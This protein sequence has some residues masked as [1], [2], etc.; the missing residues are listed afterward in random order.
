[1]LPSGYLLHSHGKS[2]F[3]IGKP[4]I[5]MIHLYRGYVSHNLRVIHPSFPQQLPPLLAWSLQ[6]GF[7]A[8]TSDAAVRPLLAV[9]DHERNPFD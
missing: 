4:S 9:E 1:M 7:A 2:Q 8:V 3:L 6:L 5:S